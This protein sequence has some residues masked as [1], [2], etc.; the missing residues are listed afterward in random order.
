MSKKFIIWISVFFLLLI[1]IPGLASFDLFGLAKVIGVVTV[2]LVSLAIRVWT[3]QSKKNSL[4]KERI[5]LNRNDRFHIDKTVTSFKGLDADKKKMFLD[6]VALFLA[7]IP[8][9]CEHKG[10]LDRDE[11]ISVACHY[12]LSSL[13]NDEFLISPKFKGV[14]IGQTKE[15]AGIIQVSI[16]QINN[17]LKRDDQDGVNRF[18]NS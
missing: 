4:V 11:C 6:R 17:E 18:W 2:V 10:D 5:I 13:E 15:T 8:F 3:N 9:D 12:I 14:Y 1:S 16:E 7:T